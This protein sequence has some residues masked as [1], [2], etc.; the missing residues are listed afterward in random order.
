MSM[1]DTR[2]RW[3]EYYSSR[4][5]AN[6]PKSGSSMEVYATDEGQQLT[7]RLVQEATHVDY[8]SSGMGPN[9]TGSIVRQ[10]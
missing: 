2:N 10:S 7:R 8:Q 4:E 6:H 3:A 5:A 9:S 1:L